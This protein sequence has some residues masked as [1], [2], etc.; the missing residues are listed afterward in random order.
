MFYVFKI[1]T[2]TNTYI[3]KATPEAEH[4]F[5]EIFVEKFSETTQIRSEVNIQSE[6]AGW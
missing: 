4:L 2:K 5:W 1:K 3:W 6:H